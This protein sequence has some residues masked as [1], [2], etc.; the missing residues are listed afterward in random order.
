MAPLLLLLCCC[1]AAAQRGGGGSRVE[2]VVSG[3]RLEPPFYTIVP[4]PATT[5]IVAG[6]SYKFTAGPGLR[7]HPFYIGREKP[8]QILDISG[9]PL[10]NKGDSFTF[11]LADDYTSGLVFFC[12]DHAFMTAPLPVM[13]KPA[14][15]TFAV[16]G[17][18]AVAPY[19]DI[20]PDP[21]GVVFEPGVTYRFVARGI[22]AD[23]R[24]ASPFTVGSAV[25]STAFLDATTLV[26]YCPDH[27]DRAMQ[28]A[29]K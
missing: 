24:A 19:Y 22:R 3:G 12:T 25:G 14:V 28:L 21:L 10:V 20:T 23:R 8:Q 6:K 18:S 2:F 26:Y 4:D 16:S 13:S 11:S 27:P 15:V 9:A 29:L 7:E 1:G 17:G 5:D